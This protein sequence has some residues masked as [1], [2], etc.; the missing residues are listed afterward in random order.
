M[1]LSEQPLGQKPIA[2][3]RATAAVLDM[4]RLQV[5]GLSPAEVRET[6]ELI[7]K[8]AAARSSILRDLYKP[9]LAPR[10]RLTSGHDI[11]VLGLGTW[12]AILI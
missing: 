11:P 5:D 1:S 9:A 4:R 7:S 3:V 12:C 2:E 8:Q 10:T 6:E